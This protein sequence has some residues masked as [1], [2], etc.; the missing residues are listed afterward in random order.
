MIC[1]A[2]L[3]LYI[4]A[5]AAEALACFFKIYNGPST[6]IS[7]ISPINSFRQTPGQ[8][9]ERAGDEAQKSRGYQ[10]SGESRQ[11][12][13]A[14]Q[15]RNEDTVG[16]RYA[17]I[18]SKFS[19]GP[20]HQFILPTSTI[21]ENTWPIR[22]KNLILPSTTA[23][24][25]PA[26][27]TPNPTRANY[28]PQRPVLAYVMDE[29]SKANFLIGAAALLADYR[30]Q[31]QSIEEQRGWI[32][33][34]MDMLGSEQAV[35]DKQKADLDKQKAKLDKQKAWLDIRKLNLDRWKAHHD[36]QEAELDQKREEV[37]RLYQEPSS[38]TSETAVVDALT[39]KLNDL[40][41]QSLSNDIKVLSRNPSVICEGA[42]ES[43]ED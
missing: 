14:R 39:E 30:K 40:D 11:N 18:W 26:R 8:D 23:D 1:G 25:D 5:V 13:I 22:T 15:P 4:K 37:R 3:P 10:P 24:T 9:E 27:E 21:S 32:S 7:H 12:K 29:D 20:A 38:K 17:F 28:A 31:Q 16:R 6:R 34:H 2:I 36:R 42:R 41:L 35:L 33:Q 19:S 43:G